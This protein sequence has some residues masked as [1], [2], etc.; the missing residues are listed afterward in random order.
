MGTAIH[1]ERKS[2]AFLICNL[3]F[4]KSG[5]PQIVCGAANL[6][7]NLESIHSLQVAL[8]YQNPRWFMQIKSLNPHD[9]C[10][11]KLIQILAA[12]KI[13]SLLTGFIINFSEKGIVTPFP[14]SIP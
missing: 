13:I 1:N 14:K 12:S 7:R 11:F 2:R 3:V 8:Y 5:S 4:G 10:V 9:N 6:L